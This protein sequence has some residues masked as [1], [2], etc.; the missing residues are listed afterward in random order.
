MRY[1]KWAF[2]GFQHMWSYITHCFT[3]SVYWSLFRNRMCFW[4]FTFTVKQTGWRMVRQFY[5]NLDHTRVCH[6]AHS[7]FDHLIVLNINK[8]GAIPTVTQCQHLFCSIMNNLY[9]KTRV[10]GLNWRQNMGMQHP[11]LSWNLVGHWDMFLNQPSEFGEEKQPMSDSEKHFMDFG[12]TIEGVI[13][14][15]G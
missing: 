13:P 2:L 8:Q 12:Y 7:W 15:L 14:W 5:T 9:R 6:C 3:Y 4:K 10:Y 1:L 11:W